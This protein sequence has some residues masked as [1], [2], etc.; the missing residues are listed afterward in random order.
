VVFFKK[1][2]ESSMGVWRLIV[3]FVIGILGGSFFANPLLAGAAGISKDVLKIMHENGDIADETFEQLS[4]L[5]DEKP[6]KHPLTAYWD[7]GLRLKSD[8]NVFK[9]K[10]GGRI[11]N[12]WAVVSTDD[13]VKDAF[14]DIPVNGSGTE[15][16]QARFYMAGVI[17]DRFTFNAEYDFAGTDADFTDVWIG[18]KNVPWL[19]EV[20]LGHQKEPFSLERLNSIKYTTFIER[21]LPVVFAPGR[22]TGIKFHQST[23]DKR[24]GWGVGIYKEVKTSDGFDDM[25]NHNITARFTCAPWMEDNG[26]QLLHLGLGYSH[27]FSDKD[28]GYR[29]RMFPESHP[30]TV[31]TVDTGA[32]GN[33][34]DVDLVNPEIALVLG[35]LSIQSEYVGAYLEREAGKNLDFSGY[36]VFC[37]YFL[38]G[39]H[40]QYVSGEAGGEFGRINPR[41]PFTLGGSG[42]GSWQLALR[43][44][45]VDLNDCE[46]NGGEED[47]FTAGMNWYL[48]ANLRLSLNYIRAEL[49]DRTRV[50]DGQTFQ[51]DD[52]GMDTVLMRCQ[53]D[54]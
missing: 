46:I 36:Y 35:P 27:K 54:F 22:N 1:E 53:M 47:N 31:Y 12:D 38:T 40:R 45:S 33:V 19:G 18:I 44:S 14:S 9:I 30:G 25:N 41:S 49:S 39:E 42:W 11:L 10:F 48:N 21:A 20:R 34:T 6:A 4:A 26:E 24:M 51:L 15:M 37:S 50:I 17:Y 2:K 3:F 13:A 52:D 32:F 43:Y 28:Q 7:N 16:R 29:Y 5:A 23:A 8:D